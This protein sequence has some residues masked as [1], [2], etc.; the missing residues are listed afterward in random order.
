M[1]RDEGIGAGGEDQPVVGRL[2]GA[3]L[4]VRAVHDAPGTIHLAHGAARV[5][6]DAVVLVPGPVVEDDLLQRLLARE[7]G[8]QQD[9]VV[10]GVRFGAED[11]DL[12]QIG[13][14]LQQLLERAHA[15]HAVAHHHQSGFLHR[16]PHGRFGKQKRRP[17]PACAAIAGRSHGWGRLRPGLHPPAPLRGRT[18]WPSSATRSLLA[19]DVPGRGRHRCAGTLGEG[20]QRIYCAGCCNLHGFRYGIHNV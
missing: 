6:R 19:M 15:G 17:H 1:G 14:D 7:H 5:Q 20:V 3:A 4:G 2:D 9:A 16:D 18:A 8:R 13:R 10:V 11:G 12:V